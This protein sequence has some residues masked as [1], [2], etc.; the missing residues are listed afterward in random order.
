MSSKNKKLQATALLFHDHGQWVTGSDPCMTHV[1]HPKMVTH[2]TH[3]PLTHFRLCVFLSGW[4]T[5]AIT[6]RTK[7]RE[8]FGPVTSKRGL[9]LDAVNT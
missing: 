7:T 8:L 9:F 4:L 2:L 6:Q 5:A 1:T 3:D